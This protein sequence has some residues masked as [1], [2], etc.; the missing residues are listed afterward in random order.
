MSYKEFCNRGR[1][2]SAAI[3]LEETASHSSITNFLNAQSLTLL[4]KSV[5]TETILAIKPSKLGLTKP[6]RFD[7]Q[8]SADPAQCVFIMNPV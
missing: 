1:G 8:P 6:T 4:N 5:G 7:S 2:L 3:Q